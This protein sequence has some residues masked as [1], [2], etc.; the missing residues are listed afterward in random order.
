MHV[1]PK[2]T[3]PGVVEDEEE[4]DDFERIER[5][6][7]Y[8]LAKN[9]YEQASKSMARIVIP[10][11]P[12]LVLI[13]VQLD[14]NKTWNWGLTFLPLWIS[15]FFDCCGGCYHFFCTSALAHIEVQEAMEEE[16]AKQQE[17]KNEAKKDD[18]E[19]EEG[20]VNDT[21]AKS[22]EVAESSADANEAKTEES[23]ES[24]ADASGVTPVESDRKERLE[25][26]VAKCQEMKVG[27]LKKELESYGISTKIYFEKSEFVFAVAEAR[28]DGL[29]KT[30]IID[31]AVSVETPKTEVSNTATEGEV[32]Q[33]GKEEDDVDDDEFE[34][35][36]DEDTFHFYQQA[37][38]E[39]ENKASEAQAK[40]IGSFCNI[41]F[42][43]MIAAL[44][45][46]KLN[47]VYEERE[48][49]NFEGTSSYSTFWIL[50]PF[51][52]ISGCIISCFACAIF[53]ADGLDS[54]LNTE[55]G[56]EAPDVGEAGE[57]A[58]AATTDDNEASPVILT[59]PPP[60]Q[61]VE[62]VAQKETEETEAQTT[63]TLDG[64]G[65]VDAPA[66]VA[67]TDLESGMDDLD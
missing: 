60:S 9:R 19:E 55:D 2:Q 18:E 39:A 51:L 33:E 23:A 36:M 4:G 7:E 59:P 24:K 35:E 47:K 56:G 12:L 58:A 41:I 14:Q 54:A 48:D 37:E 62:D 45:V 21:E 50:F 44:F 13:V 64:A 1:P 10:E 22:E 66:E 16:I 17:A 61:P 53:G 30:K 11:I 31:T 26:E 67:D 25:K 46:A 32:K 5:S 29:P 52:L 65:N 15:M 8:Q 40:A 63:N 20:K 3:A 6:P 42:Q 27:D 49:E 57:A 34:F 38:M 28:V 43:A